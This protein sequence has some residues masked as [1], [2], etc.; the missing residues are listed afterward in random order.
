MY[1]CCRSKLLIDQDHSHHWCGIELEIFAQ[2]LRQSDAKAARRIEEKVTKDHSSMRHRVKAARIIASRNGYVQEPWADEVR[3][4]VGMMVWNCISSSVDL[5]EIWETSDRSGKTMRRIGFTDTL[6]D[7]LDTMDAK[8]SWAEPMFEP[9]IVKPRDW[10]SISDGCYWGDSS[11][12]S[13]FS[14]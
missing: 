5:F 12:L 2:G 6:R 7:A 3:A 8:L 11:K 9:M 10:T 1:G 14:R 13:Y 4:K